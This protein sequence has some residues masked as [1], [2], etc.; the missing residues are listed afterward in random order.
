MA[1]YAC[2][3]ARG[4]S[5]R[6][7]HKNIKDFRG[8][9]LIA[10]PIT[11]ALQSG[12]FEDV[13][14]STDDEEIASVA[15]AY[16]AAVPF[17]RS[18]ELADDF[19]GTYAVIA[20]AYKQLVSLGKEVDGI[21]CIYATSPLLNKEYLKKAFDIFVKSQKD[22]LCSVCEFPFP[23]QR[24]F[25]IDEN[26]CV[27]YREPEFAMTR[28][29]DLP[30]TFQDCG[31]F[32]FYSKKLLETGKSNGSIPFVMPRHRVIDIDTPEDWN[33]ACAMAKVVEELNLE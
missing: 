12:I 2:I 11:A 25:I 30:K 23:I 21:C 31:L 15:K 29:Q 17:M 4:G 3:P 18:K 7:P 26:G 24:A 8:K 19:T 14:I 20:D 13:I 28:S 10:Y 16:G 27:Q 33:V 32:Y 9:P 6:I 1:F 22:C 5:K